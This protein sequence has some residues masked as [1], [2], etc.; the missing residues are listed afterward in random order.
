MFNLQDKVV[1]VTGGT[2][3]VGPGVVKALLELGTQVHLPLRR[4]E[5]LIAL[6]AQINA[7]D[8]AFLTATQADM[9]N[10]ASVIAFYQQVVNT[11]GRIDAVVNL[12]GGYAGGKPVHET[13]WAIW[14]E[15]LMINFKSVVLSCQQAIP[16]MLTQGT[17]GAIVNVGTN[18]ALNPQPD[19]GA[20]STAKQGVLHL[21]EVLAKELWPQ[22]ITV[23]AI[24]PSNINTAFYRQANPDADHSLRV[25]PVQI[26]QVIAFLISSAGQF[27]TGTF[28]PIAGR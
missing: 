15:Q 24:I 17:G 11:L 23:N 12:V 7:P 25:T 1:V 2:G 19:Y 10:E 5:A 20:Y 18:L 4:V 14:E 9:L 6:R 3:E 16:Y 28:I 27:T 21:T 13:E 26:G 8:D 22:K